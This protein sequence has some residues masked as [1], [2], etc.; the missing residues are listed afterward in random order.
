MPPRPREGEMPPVGYIQGNW[1]WTGNNWEPHGSGGSNT[2]EFGLDKILD[3]FKKRQEERNRLTT[4]FETK[5]PFVFDEVLAQK[6]L[7][8]SE[9]L[10]PYY[11]Q[12]LGDFLQGITR[13]RSR[14]IED[15]RRLLGE[16]E[17][18]VSQ[19]TE[20]SKANLELALE[21]AKEGASSAGL[22][23]SGI[24]KRQEGLLERESTTDLRDYLT[25]AGRRRAEVGRD[26]RRTLEDIQRTEAMETRDIERERQ[27]Q[28]KLLS[29]TLTK[30]AGIKR[31]FARRQ[32]LGPFADEGNSGDILQGLG[33]LI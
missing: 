33:G 23:Q 31:E 1:R 5:N 12:T 30:E 4:E 21:K 27:A 8:A 26:T 22:L 2:G 14:G 28:T 20:Q 17:T 6:A 15:E 24:A 25:T 19:Y 11:K 10:D 16:L 18:D 29:G 3:E 32:F 9:Q 13:Q 7:Q